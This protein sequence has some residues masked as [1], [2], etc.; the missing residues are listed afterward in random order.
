M[1]FS[2]V[3]VTMQVSLAVHTILVFFRVAL[4]YVVN[5]LQYMFVVTHLQ[6]AYEPCEGNTFKAFHVF[7]SLV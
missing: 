2:F 7:L 3:Q 4:W 6:C 1:Y 5:T